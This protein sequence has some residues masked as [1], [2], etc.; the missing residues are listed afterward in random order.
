MISSTAASLH[1]ENRL[2]LLTVRVFIKSKVILKIRSSG[3]TM[4]VEIT[5]DYILPHSHNYENKANKQCKIKL[6]DLEQFNWKPP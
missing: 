6:S 3:N 5:N 2:G 4:Y 1:K